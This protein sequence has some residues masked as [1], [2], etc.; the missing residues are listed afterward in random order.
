MTYK[1]FL[2]TKTIGLIEEFDI[3]LNNGKS[4]GNI[5]CKIDSGNDGYCVIDGQ[6]VKV[7]GENIIF[8]F[9]GTTIKTKVIDTLNVHIGD[10]QIDK[11][12]VILLT[13]KFRGKTY[14]NVKFTVAD[15]S[16][17]DYP[18]LISKSFISHL[19]LL[20]DVNKG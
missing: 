18:V 16:M 1:E 5:A 6:H 15:R 10:S 8:M 14:K 19:G 7:E 17:N 13:L 11:R 3:C 20:I 4:L 9:K 2:A 12:P